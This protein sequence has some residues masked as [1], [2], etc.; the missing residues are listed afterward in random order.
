MF[1][2]LGL[3]VLP[4]GQVGHGL[5]HQV[6]AVREGQRHRRADDGPAHRQRDLPVAANGARAVHLARLIQVLGQ[7]HHELADQEDVERREP[8]GQHHRPGGVQKAHLPKCQ[9]V[10]HHGDLEGQYHQ[11]QNHEEYALAAPELKPAQRVGHHGDD[12]GLAQQYRHGERH[13]VDEHL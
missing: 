6:P 13:G 4:L 11:H 3:E 7:A 1:N 8:H 2:Q 10:G 12:H 5:L 9:H